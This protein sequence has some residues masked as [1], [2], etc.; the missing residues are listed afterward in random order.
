MVGYEETTYEV[1]LLCRNCNH[2]WIENVEK[3][4]YIRYEKDN[5]YMIKRG[6]SYKDRKLFTCPSCKAH[7]KIARLPL[8]KYKKI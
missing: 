5:N 3:G 7:K 8:N 1:R 4:T 6:D 2:E